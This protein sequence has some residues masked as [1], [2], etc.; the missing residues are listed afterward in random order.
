M[1]RCP[2]HSWT[3]RQ[4]Q[5]VSRMG[6]GHVEV[7]LALMDASSTA[8]GEQPDQRGGSVTPDGVVDV[9]LLPA[10]LDQARPAENVEMMRQRGARHLHRLL[11]LPRRNLAVGAHQEEEHLEPGQMRQGLERENVLLGRLELCQG[12]RCSLC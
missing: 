8:G 3:T 7:P 5:E 10:T 1:W 2:R 11:N 9:A 4:Q 6:D 12:E